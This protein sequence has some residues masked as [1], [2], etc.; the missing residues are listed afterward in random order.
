MNT[1]ALHLANPPIIEAVVDIDCDLPPGQDLLSLEAEARNIFRDAYPA[2]R[3][4]YAQ[5]FKFEARGEDP[6]E[7]SS[8]HRVE[9]FQF[10]MSGSEQLVNRIEVPAEDR[11]VGLDAYFKAGIQLRVRP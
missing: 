7:T 11:R 1:P 6:P 4:R 3:R 8:H 2:F 5:E 9:A 10:L